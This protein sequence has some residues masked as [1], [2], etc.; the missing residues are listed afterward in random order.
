LGVREIA[1]VVISDELRSGGQILRLRCAQDGE[2]GNLVVGC[3]RERG[4]VG[5]GFFNFAGEAGFWLTKVR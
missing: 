3:Q 5:A 4:K 1:R 2:G